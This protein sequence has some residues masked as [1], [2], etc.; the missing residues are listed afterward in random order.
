ML[1]RYAVV[2]SLA[3]AAGLAL[4]ACGGSDNPAVGTSGSTSTTAAASSGST[5]AGQPG[6]GAPLT[7]AAFV[8]KANAICKS[9]NDASTKLT[10]PTSDPTKVTAND[11]PAWNQFLLKVIPYGQQQQSQLKALTPPAA[12]QATVAG[13]IAKGDQVL[14]DVQALQQAAA[15][16][17]VN[18]FKTAFTQSENDGNAADQA[19]TSYGLTQCGSS[20]SGNSG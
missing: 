3:A 15:A 19:A 9:V 4:A 20:S 10:P 5:T 16:G 6:S 7:K 12:D 11:L 14:A 13:I 18:A 8:S 1:K 2:V 17:N